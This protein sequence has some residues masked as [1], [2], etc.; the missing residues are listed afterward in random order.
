MTGGKN[1]QKARWGK[2]K[3]PPE[4]RVRAVMQWRRVLGGLGGGRGGGEKLP[5]TPLSA[6]FPLPPPTFFSEEE[7]YMRKNG[8]GRDGT[9]N[10]NRPA[11][12]L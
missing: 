8:I 1:A 11:P 5:Q 6:V 12:S 7:R 9:R 4:F 2:T 3:T 10:K